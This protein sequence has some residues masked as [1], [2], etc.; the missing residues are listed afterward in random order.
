[1]AEFEKDFFAATDLLDR[2]PT[3]QLEPAPGEAFAI[4]PT[5]EKTE[6][7]Q[8]DLTP[9]LT[10]E[11]DA[12]FTITL[13]EPS[14][15][16]KKDNALDLEAMIEAMVDAFMAQMQQMQQQEQLKAQE[17]PAKIEAL[18]K[19]ITAIIALFRNPTNTNVLP[20]Q[21]PQDE[22][23]DQNSTL[24][25][26]APRPT[27]K[28]NVNDNGPIQQ[29]QPLTDAFGSGISLGGASTADGSENN[30]DYESEMDHAAKL[31][32]NADSENQAAFNQSYT[33]MSQGQP[34]NSTQQ[35]QQK[36]PYS[37]P[38][39]TRSRDAG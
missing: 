21:Q 23:H 26:P 1:M 9:E 35:D 29:N 8:R 32:D 10:P 37:T 13:D 33:A 22:L 38:Q 5:Q 12:D 3:P 27:Q 11:P 34:A 19:T 31:I 17:Q 16:Q 15:E 30:L 6:Q 14:P 36:S 20:T 24:P 2:Q 7:A 28:N 39:L 4:V 18:T 25:T